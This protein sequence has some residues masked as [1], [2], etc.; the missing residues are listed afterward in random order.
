VLKIGRKPTDVIYGRVAIFHVC[1]KL[2]LLD[3]YVKYSCTKMYC[4]AVSHPSLNIFLQYQVLYHGLEGS[5]LKYSSSI[6]AL[7]ANLPIIKIY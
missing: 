5:F 1:F 4:W 6:S 3:T 2:W 7:K